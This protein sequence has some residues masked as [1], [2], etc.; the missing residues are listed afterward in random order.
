M[1][2]FRFLMA[3][4]VGI[5]LIP[6]CSYSPLRLGSS[7]TGS[8]SGP[9]VIVPTLTPTPLGEGVASKIDHDI[10]YCTA[11]NVDLKLDLYFP[12]SMAIPAPLVVYVHGGA[13]MGQ[14]KASGAGEIDFPLILDSFLNDGFIFGAVNYRLAPLFKFPAMIEDVKCAI[15]FLRTNATSY[16]INPNE[17]GAWGGSAGGHLVSL[18]GTTDASA[19]F[20]VG[21]YIDQSS[22]VEAVADLF[23]HSD[24]PA[25]VK[26]KGHSQLIKMVFGDFSLINASPDTYVTPDDPPFLILHGDADQSVP[27]DQAQ[28]FYNKLIAAGVPAELVIVHGGPHGL[29][30][31]SETPSP[32]QLSQI[33]VGF[34][35]KY[36]K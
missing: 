2:I 3:V 6:V 14:D 8:P 28:G 18:L 30:S 12:K 21:Q 17:I 1:K 15:R 31:P 34:F 35:K 27:L 13:W 20:D 10:T 23:G 26:E 24:L 7:P 22:R 25:Y 11:D 5:V 9:T 29:D 33:I 36:L 19:G 32:S 4:I 16:N